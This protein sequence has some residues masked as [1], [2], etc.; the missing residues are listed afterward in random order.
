MSTVNKISS[1]QFSR[2]L[3]SYTVCVGCF[4][5]PTKRVV[6]SSLSLSVFAYM[7]RLVP[8]HR[9]KVSDRRLRILQLILPFA[10]AASC[11][12]SFHLID[13]ALPY[14]SMGLTANAIPKE[15]LTV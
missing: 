12:I 14:R 1:V 6:T 10:F 3:A 5:R 11:Y 15:L 8:T 9:S 4:I 2:F 13:T 7:L